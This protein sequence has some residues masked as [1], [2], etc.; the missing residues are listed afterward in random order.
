MTCHVCQSGG[1]HDIDA[2]GRWP[3]CL[4]LFFFCFK[5]KKNNREFISFCYE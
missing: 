1:T 4:K 2:R 5:L 3:Q